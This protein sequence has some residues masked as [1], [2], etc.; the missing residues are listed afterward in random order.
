MHSSREHALIDVRSAA[1]RGTHLD[2]P[3]VALLDCVRLGV[4]H[5]YVCAS[6]DGMRSSRGCALLDAYF[7]M[8]RDMLLGVRL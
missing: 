5:L 3:L 7:A 1:L 2:A 4:K 6:Q 8:P